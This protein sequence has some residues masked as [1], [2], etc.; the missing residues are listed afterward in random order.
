MEEDKIPLNARLDR[1]EQLLSQNFA[2]KPK[3]I[4][5]PM[6]ARVRRGKIKQ[7]WIGILRVDENGNISG[8][9]Q[10]IEDTTIRLKDGTYHTTD[11]REILFWNGK[12]PIIIQP[13]WKLNPIKLRKEEGENNQT[14]GQKYI[15]ARMLK[16]AIILKKKAGNIIIWIA[17]IAAALFGI[18]YFMGK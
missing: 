8:E 7:G 9:K 13:T 5:I 16:D 12:F 18:N 4:K 11:G 2:E 6:K 15:M 10:K 14:Y 17:I 1:M 3:K